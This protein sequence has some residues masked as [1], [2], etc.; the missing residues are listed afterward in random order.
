[1]ETELEPLNRHDSLDQQVRIVT[2]SL[3]RASNCSVPKKTVRLKGPKWKAS[4]K[5]IHSL[6]TCKRLHSQWVAAGKIPNHIYHIQL[7]SEK[8]VLRNRQRYEHALDRK[9]LHEQLM[10]KPT[11]KQFNQLIKRN[12]VSSTSTQC[13]KIGERDCYSTEQQCEAFAKYY[14]DLAVPKENVYENTYLNLCSVRQKVVEQYLKEENLT[15]IM[16]TVSDIESGI[17]KLNSGKSPDEF[18]LSAEHLKFAKDIVAETITPLF[19]Q[20]L[21][22]RSIPETFK[23]GIL[24]PVIKKDKDPCLVNSY[25]GITVTAVLGKLFEYSLLEKLNFENQTDLQF[26]FTKGLSPLMS[27][28]LITEARAEAKRSKSTLYFATLDVQS[29]F[30]VVQH[31][32]LFDK[33][34]DRNICPTYWLI[35]KELYNGITTKVKWLGTFSDSFGLKQGVRQGGV[36]STHLYKIF[37]EDQ[38]LELETNS[39]GFMLGNIYIGAT[40]VADDLAYLS[41]TPET[42]QLMLNVGY[43]YSDQHHYKIHPTKTKIVEH[44]S[45]KGSAE[46]KWTLGENEIKASKETTHLG[47]KR[48]ASNECEINIG[49]RIKLARRTKYALMNSGYHGTNGLS[50]AT[51]YQIYKTY[52]L[53]RLLYGLEVLPLKKVHITTLEKFHKNSLRIIQSLPERTASAAVYL[54]LGAVPV[55]AEIHRRQLSMLHAILNSDNR[56]INEVLDRQMSVNYD[57]KDSFFYQIIQVLQQYS[58]PDIHTLKQNIPSKNEWKATINRTVTK[59]WTDSLVRDSCCKST[60]RFLSTDNILGGRVHPVWRTTDNSVGDVR[61]AVIKAR[62][63]TGTYILQK[64]VH[65]FSQYRE[66]PTCKLCKQ[67]EEDLCHML[68]YCPLLREDRKEPYTSFKNTVVRCIGAVAWQQSFSVSDSLVRLILDC[69]RF[70]HMFSG[71]DLDCVERLSR[72]LCYKIHIKR[73]SLLRAHN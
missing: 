20:I 41:P 48:T 3:M 29:A 28:L 55:E 32:I 64:N 18:G 54:L 42:L 68:L 47:L 19:N 14:E 70:S 10:T 38:L 60:L 6:K 39:L 22:T 23:T 27:S 9:M 37:V 66:N 67:Q 2:E 69:T 44:S 62:M 43:R 53:P 24:T 15:E 73:L 12:K 17:Q 61:K 25:R 57:N 31:T 16:F 36:L 30:D 21:E 65:T 35:I 8:K 7:K 45:E 1:M 51:S 5:V 4:P 52:V 49:D 11:S 63:L 46:Y 33:L 50:P 58:L 13:L 72:N 34:L 26:G 56:R 71:E 59:Y 40:A